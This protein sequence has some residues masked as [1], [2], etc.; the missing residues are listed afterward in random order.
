MWSSTTSPRSLIIAFAYTDDLSLTALAVAVALYAVTI[1]MR[2]AGIRNGTAYFVVALAF[3]VAMLESGIHPTIA[4]VAVGL[5]ATA[6]PPTREALEHAGTLWRSFR[7]QPTPEYARSA[8]T[9][10]RHA[11]SP[12]ERLQAIWQ[13]WTSYVIVPLFALA[14]AGVS[15]SR[16]AIDRGLTSRITLGILFGLVVGKLV[17]ITGATWLATRRRLGRF[18]LTIPWPP[19][20]GAATVAGIGFTVAL[21]IADIS[22][23]GEQLQDAQLGIL[24]ASVLATRAELVRV[25]C[26]R[27]SPRPARRAGEAST[28]APIIDLATPVDPDRDHIRGPQDAAVTLVEYGD[29]ECPYCG[30]AEPVIRELLATS[31]GELRYVFRH[32]PLVDVHEHAAIAAEAAEA[33][34]EQGAFWEMHDRL[35]DRQSTLGIIDLVNNANEIGLDVPRFKKA[36]QSRKY[37]LRVE[38]DVE[39]ANDSGVA[40][41]PSFFINGRRHEGAY[42]LESLRAAIAREARTVRTVAIEERSAQ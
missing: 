19:L 32:L 24:G 8:S 17:G 5:L 30:R 2:R 31:G 28:A 21:L 23:E 26:H 15:L 40:G 4:G 20:V 3:W 25:P 37:A 42:D 34:G 11:V 41:T 1:L 27:T 35:F 33:A 12:N 39:S 10:V 13:P 6:Y 7:E 9:S 29:F 22:F 36:L 16:E 18:P 14:N 38:R